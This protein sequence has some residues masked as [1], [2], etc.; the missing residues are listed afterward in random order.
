[1]QSPQ[2]SFPSSAS[3]QRLR[4][5]AILPH[6]VKPALYLRGAMD[7]VRMPT[8]TVWPDDASDDHIGLGGGSTMVY[9]RRRAWVVCKWTN[10][11]L[12]YEADF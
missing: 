4:Q 7:C 1:M 12:N 2:S 8:V 5:R 3:L 6:R 11:I 9:H 10:A